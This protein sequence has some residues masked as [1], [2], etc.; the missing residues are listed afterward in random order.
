MRARMALLKARRCVLIRAIKLN[1]KPIEML[2][3]SP[4]GSVPV[5]VVS[6]DVII[7]ESLE[8]M[9]WALAQNDPDDLLHI[10]QPDAL[11]DMITT[12]IEFE[13][14][15]IPSLEAY[16]CARRYHDD[17]LDERRLACQVY[18]QQLEDTLNVQSFLYSNKE[19][20]LD[21]ALMPFI[22]KFSR[23]EKKWYRNSPYPHL[24]AW[25]ERYMQSP[26]FSKV[27][28]EHEL[29]LERRVDIYFAS[30]KK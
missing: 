2:A 20:V 27:M 17:S 24:R 15:F 6:D 21:I 13:I 10:K 11:P 9:L 7:E 16:S 3:V 5:L 1:N 18:L 14:G 19:S 26:V 29:W 23:I 28:A 12:I 4:K 30:E 22:R 8:V 25:L